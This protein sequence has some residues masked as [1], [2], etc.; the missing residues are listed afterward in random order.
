MNIAELHRVAPAFLRRVGIAGWLNYN[1][2]LSFR[3]RHYVI[4]I[5]GGIGEELLRLRPGF[6]SA[7][8]DVF[9]DKGPDCFVDVG[10]NIGQ[11]V[12]EAFASKTWSAY[13][14]LE[15]NVSACG[16]LEVLVRT[17]ALPVTLLPWGAGSAARPQVLY[18][19]G[20][21]D[22][23]ATMAPAARPGA[24]AAGMAGWAASYPL[25]TMLE[26]IGL[27]RSVLI[28]IDVEGFEAE[29]LSG[30]TRILQQLR[31]IV[32]CEVLRAYRRC[33][34]AH[35]DER[36]S[37]LEFLLKEQ[38]YR[39]FYLQTDGN[40]GERLEKARQIES[41]PRELWQDNPTGYDYL[42]LPTEMQVP[43]SALFGLA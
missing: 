14:A 3:D 35:T 21:R 24:Y 20:P 42:F 12:L 28:K 17:N 23:A 1:H 36:M 19:K 4:P 2:S 10:A 37:K 13:Y 30:A 6:K 18:A 40:T 26:Q 34:L 38:R 8:I 32:V 27:P 39:I 7:I 5:H 11:T 15:P 22:G 25:D 31:P 43:A 41:F 29:V 9:R 16:Y 33:E